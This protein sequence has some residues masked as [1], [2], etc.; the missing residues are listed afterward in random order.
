LDFSSG[1]KAFRFAEGR[2]SKSNS[3][4]CADGGANFQVTENRTTHDEQAGEN[5]KNGSYVHLAKA[6]K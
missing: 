1:R 5:K 4:N 2:K 3:S 6:P